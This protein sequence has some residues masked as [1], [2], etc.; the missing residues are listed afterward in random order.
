MADEG[1]EPIGGYPHLAI[2]TL[3]HLNRLGRRIPTRTGVRLFRLRYATETANGD[4][5]TAS[6]LV[7]LPRRGRPR[8]LVS[9]QHGTAS[10]RTA[11]PSAKDPAN[12]L[13]PAAVFAGDGYA[14]VAPDYV[15]YGIS[16]ER[17]DYYLA[18]HMATVVRGAIAAAWE[19]LTSAGADVAPR[20]ALAG[21]SEGAHASLVAQLRIEAEPIPG[22]EL[23]GT[24]P[25]AA[26]VDLAGCGL[27]GALRG[28][29]RFCSLY[30]AWLASTYASHY[31][32]PLTDVLTAYWAGQVADLFDGT[33]DG[34]TTVARL[35]TDPR[36][37]L[38]PGFVR[39]VEAG[40][41][42]WFLDRLRENSLLDRAPRTPVRLFFGRAD[43]DVT[44]DQAHAYASAHPGAPIET[45]CVGD[46]DHEQTLLRAVVPLRDWIGGLRGA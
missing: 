28:E 29:S 15:G 31:G 27:R 20:L 42:H 18:D 38:D 21:F 25:V 19:A 17:H 12:G 35:P 2:R 8:G 32:G 34:D 9:W 1:L 43:T 11:A 37:L 22:L 26:A 5:T 6:A 10:L 23:V 4:P 24:A 33:V 36:D 16:A 44:P 7:A 45:V 30:L 39:T 3:L 13:L 41:P 14:L 40:A 46:H